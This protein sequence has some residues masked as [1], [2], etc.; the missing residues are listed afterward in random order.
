[1]DRGVNGARELFLTKWESSRVV[2][3]ISGLGES[4]SWFFYFV[5][6]VGA[7]SGVLLFHKL[8]REE[9]CSNAA[10]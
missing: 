1:M 8:L 7:F 6:A 10:S 5:D 4:I 2:P 3:F 9:A